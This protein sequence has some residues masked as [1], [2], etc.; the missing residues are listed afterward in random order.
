MFRR[1][2][3]QGNPY[4]AMNLGSLYEKGEFITAD[5][6]AAT[7]WYRAA[8]DSGLETAVR[9]DVWSDTKIIEHAKAFIAAN[10]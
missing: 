7:R 10:P 9:R 1:A 2:A 5:K 8:L 6:Q 4:A 3:A